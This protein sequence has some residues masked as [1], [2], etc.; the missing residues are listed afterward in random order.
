M[1][2][3]VD[4]VTQSNV[5]LSENKQAFKNLTIKEK[6]KYS[7]EV[8]TVEPLL[9]A[10]LFAA[11]ICLP[12]L[13]TLELEK[14]CRANLQQNETVCH[15]IRE[16]EHKNFSEI[17]D[18]IIVLLSNIHSWQTPC[19]NIAPL[20]L[21][22]FL[23]SYSDRHQIRKPFM[24]LPLIGE[25]FAIIGCILS[26]IFMKEWPVEIQGILQTIVPSFFGGSTMLIMAVFSYVADSTTIEMRTMKVAMVQ[27]VLNIAFPIGQFLSGILFIYLDYIGVL[28]ISG[29]FYIF[30]ILYGVCFIKEI[31][32]PIKSE[33]SLLSDLF[34]PTNGLDTLKVL[35]QKK[36]DTN[37]LFFW[38]ILAMF[39][40]VTGVSTVDLTTLFL[41]LQKIFGWTGPDFSLYSTANTVIHLTGIVLFVPL[42][43]KI[44]HLNDVTILV[45]TFLD[46]I[47]TTIITGLAGSN[48][49]LYLVLPRRNF[50]RSTTGI[51]WGNNATTF[52][53]EE[54]I[55][56]AALSDIPVRPQARANDGCLVSIIT[57]IT[58]IALRSL[59]TKVVS[60]DD[61]GKAQSLFGIFEAIGI[62]FLTPIFNTVFVNTMKVLPSA[63]IFCQSF[64]YGICFLIAIFFYFQNSELKEQ[65]VE[66][67]AEPNNVQTISMEQ[68]SR[69]SYNNKKMET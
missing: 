26:V 20:I 16:G 35:I 38:S 7:K 66:V 1:T 29:C 45:F 8:V 42:F 58:I 39:F 69:T 25:L 21:V 18:E 47:A 54:A 57:N 63:F 61:L 49:V 67:T 44:L 3:T 32:Q 62:A 40:I 50:E 23:G 53:T 14:A 65:K 59:A 43:T 52:K 34:D 46:K 15:A 22:F 55:I 12:A 2:S 28:V 24:I 33:K 31:K 4:L 51:V 60:E 13:L 41:Y 48:V 19:Q 17:N 64:A 11:V 5:D 36:K 27:T 10:Y 68:V 30:G 37:I 9:A 6:F 56:A